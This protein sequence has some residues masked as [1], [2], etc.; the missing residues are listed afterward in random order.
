[1]DLLR[2]LRYFVAVAEE[3]HFSRAAE[4]LHMA[5]P[6]L[7]QRIR[8]LE[9]QLGVEL[10]IRTTRSVELTPA[11]A[12]LLDE[13][14]AV[15]GRVERLEAT[16]AAARAGD[17]ATLRV[18]LPPGVPAA[19]LAGAVAALAGA[20]PNVRVEPRERADADL[21]ADVVDRRLD[22]ALLRWPAP[23][24]ARHGPPLHRELGALLAVGD[25]LAAGAE[26]ELSTLG[27]TRRPLVLPPRA[28]DPDGHDATLQACHA[29]G[30][31]PG[32]V[33]AAETVDFA[34]GL[35]LTT[36]AV[37]L[38]EAPAHVPD[39]TTWRPVA[40]RPL[41][42]TSVVTWRPDDQR[43]VIGLAAGLLADALVATGRWRMGDPLPRTH[44]PAVR[45]R[46]ADAFTE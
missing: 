44:A 31:A 15:L 35:V 14:R 43:P 3:L 13:A 22:L 1:M 5:Q 38:L 27:A 30:Y 46:P 8:A 40:G 42:A 4:R 41:A 10:L 11:G 34:A 19:V 24:T 2:H 17:V 25:A 29:H 33:L 9:R 28:A 36:G 7:S 39:G 18:G 20:R 16:M 26:V 32:E 12:L 6:P 37:A 23:A 45:P 21:R